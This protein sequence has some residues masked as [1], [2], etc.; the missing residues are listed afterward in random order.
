MQSP[1]HTN[2]YCCAQDASFFISFLSFF[3]YRYSQGAIKL[4]K[5]V[6][7]LSQRNHVQKYLDVDSLQWMVGSLGLVGKC[8]RPADSG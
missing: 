5:L 8:V 7:F 1:L 4:F 6:P 2:L 3:F